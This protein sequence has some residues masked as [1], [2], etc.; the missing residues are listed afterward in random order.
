MYFTFASSCFGSH[1]N[2]TTIT[3]EYSNFC[4]R[5]I[6][7][8]ILSNTFADIFNFH[9]TCWT[10]ICTSITTGSLILLQSWKKYPISCRCSY[11]SCK[12]SF[13][14]LFYPSINLHIKYTYCTYYLFV[15]CP[16]HQ[17]ILFE[18]FKLLLGTRTKSIW[19]FVIACS[20]D[21]FP[22]LKLK[23]WLNWV[24]VIRNSQFKKKNQKYAIQSIHHTQD[25]ETNLI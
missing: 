20:T 17:N 14:C 15:H 21:F 1:Q 2:Y 22:I 11:E 13:G 18:N 12:Y 10:L 24:K 4:N 19:N 8:F 6:G 25:R 16:F 7:N 9:T 23:T 3:F 5:Y